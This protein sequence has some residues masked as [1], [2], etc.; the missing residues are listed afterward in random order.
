MKQLM[1]TT[2]I[3]LSTLVAFAAGPGPKVQQAFMSTFQY[4]KDVKWGEHDNRYEASFMLSD[5][6]YNVVYDE[7][8]NI[9]C[10]NRYYREQN[11]PLVIRT[12]LEKRFSGKKIFGVTEFSTDQGIAYYI[13]LEDPTSWI[14][15]KADLD[16]RIKVESK[17]R[18]A[19]ESA[20][21][22]FAGKLSAERSAFTKDAFDAL[23]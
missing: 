20:P 2:A 3:A 1:I 23:Y 22:S 14:N 21:A 6:R 10:A 17:F 19:K 16:G 4:A 12:G 13:I 7:N 18:K 8:G 5:I 9:V 15:V 11:L